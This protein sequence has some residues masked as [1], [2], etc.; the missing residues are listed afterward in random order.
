MTVSPS[1]FLNTTSSAGQNFDCGETS[2]TPDTLAEPRPG[3]SWGEGSRRGRQSVL[4]DEAQHLSRKLKGLLIAQ[5]R[6]RDQVQP[7]RERQRSIERNARAL[8]RPS[9][10]AKIDPGA[11][12]RRRVRRAGSAAVE[13]VWVPGQDRSRSRREEA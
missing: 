6:S 7:A 3:S 1:T 5:E 4:P 11:D 12:P 10:A 13:K 2:D 8:G 9:F